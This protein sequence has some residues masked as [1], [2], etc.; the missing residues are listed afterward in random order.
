MR[1]H[2]AV[3]SPI[4]RRRAIPPASARPRLGRRLAPAAVV[5]L[6]LAC[7]AGYAARVPAWEAPD[8]AWHLAYAE[9]LAGG[10]LPR[11]VDTYE[12]HQPPLYYL[13]PALGLRI[14]GIA[15]VPRAPDNPRY[16]LATAVALH[17]PGD[18][19]APTVRWLRAFSGLLGALPVV[20][21]WAAARA[22][23]RRPR[24]DGPALA[25][26]I[27][28]AGVP[29]YVFIAHA[30]SNDTLAAGCGA[31]ATYG[32]VRWAAGG[33]SRRAVA[34]TTAGLA[35]GWLA[36]L[37]V[38]P[39][40]A[41]VP[42]AMALGL[43][44]DR[45]RGDPA[46]SRRAVGAGAT[47]AGAMAAVV[48][49]TATL[50]PSVHAALVSNVAR[51]GIAAG[52]V[53]VDQDAMARLVAGLVV[54]LWAR[55]GWLNVDLPAPLYAVPAVGA[56]L[57]GVGLW[58]LSRAAGGE[59]TGPAGGPDRAAVAVAAAIAA[60]AFAAAVRNLLADPQAQGRFMFPGLAA[61]G[62]L[63]AAGWAV[64]RGG[65]QS[66]PRRAARGPAAG[67]AALAATHG[68]A[69][70]WTLPR[71]Y[72]PNPVD[73]WVW[74]VRTMPAAPAIAAALEPD[75]GAV[76]TVGLTQTFRARRDGLR[77]AEVAVAGAPPGGRGALVATLAD[78]RGRVLGR[79][80][81]AAAALPAVGEGPPA[82]IGV[83]VPPV[84]DSAGRTFRLAVGVEGPA[85]GSGAA[86]AG[87][88]GGSQGS[89]PDGASRPGAGR[90]VSGD[91]RGDRPA[92]RFWG[93]PD[94]DRY[95]DGA[96]VVAG[97]PAAGDLVLVTWCAP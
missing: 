22:A 61:L 31:L 59:T 35:L 96:L 17:P 92:L 20:L 80:S 13:W 43:R 68:A 4:A 26:A 54:S 34:C 76:G 44:R 90:S 93:L 87:P 46:A 28:V 29:Q 39:L 79:S 24:A 53:A 95:P 82:W 21:A 37:T 51:R 3:T 91:A 60:I 72:A 16:P 84:A 88:L 77:R 48:A 57:A 78:D 33:A 2:R 94:E 12:H 55:F 14:A 62:L 75:P 83:D 11:A 38:L 19:A 30:I 81:V 41:A 58:R 52:G 69:L 8:E 40:A 47:V 9:A 25:A 36:K 64:L 1:Y 71:A 49:A 5:V 67:L 89:G 73:A 27:V 32:L 18:P 63:A 15:R 45:R 74:D 10:R 23:W 97:R 65:P 42:L 6:H 85:R 50:A 70:G 7:G 56:G 86:A 66:G